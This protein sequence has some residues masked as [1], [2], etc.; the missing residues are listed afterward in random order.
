VNQRS[1]YVISAMTFS[2]PSTPLEVTRSPDKV[3]VIGAT[4]HDGRIFLKKWILR[5]AE[6]PLSEAT[7]YLMFANMAYS[8]AKAQK[9]LGFKPRP[10]RDTF[11]DHFQDLIHRGVIEVDCA[12]RPPSI[13]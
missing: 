13:W 12:A 3:L 6:F 9:Q 1:S 4:G 10:V 2:E 7:A 5:K 11:S 8:S